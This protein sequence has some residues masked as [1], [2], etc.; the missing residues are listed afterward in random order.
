MGST[1][2]EPEEKR[3]E[4]QK[5]QCPEIITAIKHVYYNREKLY[6]QSQESIFFFHTL[7]W[8]LDGEKIQMSSSYAIDSMTHVEKIMLW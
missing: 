5:N 6:T 8:R 3:E 2:R 4:E 7:S 1:E